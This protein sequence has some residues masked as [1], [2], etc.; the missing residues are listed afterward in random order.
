MFLVQALLSLLFTVVTREAK[1]TK[2]YLA[3]AS[4]GDLGHIWA[5]YAIMGGELFWDFGSYNDMMVGNV[6]VSAGLWG[7]R[8]ATLGGVFGR[9]GR[10][11]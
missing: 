8:M 5:S 7:M 3:A 11:G 6:V 10:G 9:V 1:L 2:L 4:I